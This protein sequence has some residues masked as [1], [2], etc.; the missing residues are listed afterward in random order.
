MKLKNRR[1]LGEYFSFQTHVIPLIFF[2]S[3]KH[4]KMR[5]ITEPFFK[6]VTFLSAK[7]EHKSYDSKNG[8]KQLPSYIN[9]FISNRRKLNLKKGLCGAPHLDM[10]F[11]TKNGIKY[12][13][14]A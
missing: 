14:L 6:L 9:I 12:I 10:L 11:Q 1:F 13:E 4:V 5:G 7:G 8:Q 2:C 3:K